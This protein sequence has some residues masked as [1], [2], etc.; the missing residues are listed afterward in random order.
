MA[1]LTNAAEMA[2]AVGIDPETFREGLRDS[3]FPWHEPPDDWT[4]ETDSRQHEAM[5]TV[6]LVLL[7]KLREKENR[8]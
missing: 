7:L 2:N 3:D 8:T 6:L 5:R 1:E 4:V